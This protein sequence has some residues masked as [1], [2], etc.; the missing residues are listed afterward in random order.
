MCC[1]VPYGRSL[2]LAVLIL[3]Y[4]IFITCAVPSCLSLSLAVLIL[5]YSIFIMC[6]VSSC[7]SLSLA[8]LILYYTIFYR[9]F[10]TFMS[11]LSPAVLILYCSLSPCVLYLPVFFFSCCT[12]PF[13]S[14]PFLTVCTLF[15]AAFSTVARLNSPF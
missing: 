12:D 13:L 4:S 3:Y 1:T 2:F 11:F 7:L 10:C 6:T 14:V 15:S 8:L 5:Y 9:V